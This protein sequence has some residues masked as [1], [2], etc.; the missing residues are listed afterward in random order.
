[1]VYE[2]ERLLSEIV[3]MAEVTMQP[4]A[5]AHGEL[6]GAMI[7]AAYHRAKGNRK[8]KVIVPDSGHGTNPASAAIAGYRVVSVPSNDRGI[9]DLDAF[10]A[11]LDDEVAALMLTSPNT[12]GLFNPHIPEIAKMIHEVDG[13]MYCD[14]ANLNATMGK[15]R[16]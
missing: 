11:A 6:T 8:T 1:M 13:L 9:M 3:G 16:P 2:T 4:L 5:G 14:G 12:L 7:I 15:C 10:G